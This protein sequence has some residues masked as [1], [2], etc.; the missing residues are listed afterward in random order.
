MNADGRRWKRRASPAL[1]C[2]HLRLLSLPLFGAVDGTVINR[3][4]GSPQANA[5]VT[6]YKLGDAGMESIETVKSDAQGRFR[7]NRPVDGPHLL[8]AAWDGV[9]YNHMLPPGSS[10]S[11]VEV[12]VY[13]ATRD[14]KVAEAT[15]HMILY[16]PAA[17]ELAVNESIVFHNNSLFSLNNPESGTLR[18]FLPPQAGGKASVRAT[19]PKGMPIERA[20]E[21][22]RTA[23]VYFI[24]FPIKPG[25]TRIDVSYK[26]PFQPPAKIAGKV[27]HG[28]TAVRFVAPAGVT[29]AGAAL[30]EVGQEPTTQARVYELNG[31]DYEV[32]IQ[33]TGALRGIPGEDDEQEQ[34]EGIKTI[35]ARLYDRF[36]PILALTLIALALVLAIQYRRG[37]AIAGAKP[38]PAPPKKEKRRG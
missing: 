18:I 31:S 15:T 4:I 8:Q 33:G 36:Y 17:N 34:G 12:E 22:T 6:L 38:P 37:S 21:K 3:T 25:E 32:E 29:L 20:V 13:N 14:A 9:T 24:D 30:K 26:I 11:G 27:F 10:T 35:S 5:T 16:E 7:I 28:G 23:N 1:I 19:A 2:V